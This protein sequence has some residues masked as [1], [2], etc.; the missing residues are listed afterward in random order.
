MVRGK[1]ERMLL[2]GCACVAVLWTSQ[3]VQA[4]SGTR[5]AI[6]QEGGVAPIADQDPQPI[7]VEPEVQRRPITS[8][9]QPPQPRVEPKQ[10]QQPTPLYDPSMVD[11][12]AGWNPYYRPPSCYTN[13]GPRWYRPKRRAWEDYHPAFWGPSN[14][15]GSSCLGRHGCGGYGCGTA[16]CGGYGYSYGGGCS[17]GTCGN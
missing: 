8:V 7:D 13:Y 11:P 4:Q 6:P 1:V 9:Y 16:G 10:P 17:R 12:Y 3:S 14:Y 15:S 2:V 5:N